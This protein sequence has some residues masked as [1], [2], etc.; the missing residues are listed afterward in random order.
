MSI[1]GSKKTEARLLLDGVELM[2]VNAG[3]IEDR[4][5]ELLLDGV[6]LMYV[7]AGVVEDCLA[8]ARGCRSLTT[9]R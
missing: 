9:L 3:V 6:E 8:G 5:R 7:N 1:T 2:Y 4:G